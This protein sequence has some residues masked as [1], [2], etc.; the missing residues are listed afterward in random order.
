LVGAASDNHQETGSIVIVPELRCTA[1]H[2][3]T[4]MVPWL[5]K[6]A[7]QRP[8]WQMDASKD[9]SLHAG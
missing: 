3:V 5:W 2:G 7:K 9:P 4:V 8:R 1:A 6:R